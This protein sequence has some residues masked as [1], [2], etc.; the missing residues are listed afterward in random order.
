MS[1]RRSSASAPSWAFALIGW[2]FLAASASLSAGELVLKTIQRPA[3]PEIN[4]SIRALLQPV[5]IQLL[6]GQTPAYQLW[7]AKELPLKGRLEAPTNGLP[8]IKQ[9][10]LLGAALIGGT[11]RDYRN[12]EI[13]A[14]PYTVRL[15]LQPEDGDHLGTAEFPY[16][17]VLVPAKND[18]KADGLPAYEA[19]VK[20]S[21][22]ER[23]N[24]HPIVLSLR[25]ATSADGVLPQLNQPTSDLK[26]VRLR[27][28]VKA[29]DSGSPTNVVFDLVYQGKAR[30]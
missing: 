27:F 26:C 20:A 16:F 17:A 15:G 2:C 29:S 12:D 6:D 23:P 21:S 14:G 18:P 3:P 1:I 4:E 22:K 30:K 24:G 10:T 5:C 19:L 28:P 7:L 13:A 9:T 11:Q 8:L 25:P